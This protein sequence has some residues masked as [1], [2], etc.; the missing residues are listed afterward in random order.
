MF[1]SALSA[2]YTTLARRRGSREGQIRHRPDGRWEAH[3]RLKDGTRKS[4][5]AKT[6]NEVARKLRSFQN[7]MDKGLLAEDHKV[8]LGDYLDDWLEV[9]VKPSVRQR[10][11]KSYKGHVDLHIKPYIGR[12]PL[13]TF[14]PQQAQFWINSLMETDLSATTIHRVRATL[15]RALNVAIQWELVN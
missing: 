6:R 11:L 14:N 13:S 3:I 12:L 5:Y 1:C 2:E 15:R 4:F 9:S 10:T 7:R 8:L